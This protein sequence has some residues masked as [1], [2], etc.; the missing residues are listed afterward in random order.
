MRA[1]GKTLR[2]NSIR[3]QRRLLSEKREGHGKTWGPRRKSDAKRKGGKAAAKT[4]FDTKWGSNVKPPGE[5]Q[6]ALW[7]KRRGILF[8]RKGLQEEKSLHH[9]RTKK[10]HD[11]GGGVPLP[12]EER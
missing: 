10:K 4:T 7:T 3:R 8:S 9:P 2:E 6:R 12:E 11:L 5:R 1:R